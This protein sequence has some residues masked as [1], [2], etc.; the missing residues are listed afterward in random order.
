MGYI[1][2]L[3]RK[4]EN[5][6]K[7]YS[8]MLCHVGFTL[9]PGIYKA[10]GLDMLVMDLEHGSFCPENIGDFCMACHAQQ[11]PVIVRVQD[12]VYSC[13]SKPIDMGADGVLIPRTETME[14]VETAIRSLRFYPYGKKGVGGRGLLH[15][16]EEYEDIYKLNQNR[17]LFLQ[18]ESKQGTDL[19]DEMLTQYGDQIAGI[20]IG[21]NDMGVSMGCGLDM[22]HPDLIANIERTVQICQKHGKTVGM[23][24]GDDQ[25]AARWAKRGMNFFWI[26]T[27]LVM[28]GAEVKRNKDRVDTF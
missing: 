2:D 25:E 13:I 3:K 19:L 24:M 23:F 11:L 21:P 4:L 14:Q 27:E 7:I 16:A 1:Q 8:T 9:L 15:C 12:C 6:E 26:G 17:L 5:R 22:N 18:I 20:L 28:L 10:N